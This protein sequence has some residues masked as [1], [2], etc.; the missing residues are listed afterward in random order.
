M[1]LVQRMQFYPTKFR[2]EPNKNHAAALHD[3]MQR[4]F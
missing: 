4:R 1:A 3:E 2:E